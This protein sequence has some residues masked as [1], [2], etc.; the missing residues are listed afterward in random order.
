MF[1]HVKQQAATSTPN[2]HQ[3][4]PVQAVEWA[5]LSRPNQEWLTSRI[6]A[7]KSRTP[8]PGFPYCPAERSAMLELEPGCGVIAILLESPAGG[9]GVHE[10]Q[11]LPPPSVPGTPGRNAGTVAPLRSVTCTRMTSRSLRTVTVTVR[12]GSP[13]ALCR[14][15]LVTSS[16]SRSTAVSPAGC[17]RPSTAAANARATA[18]RS[19][20]PAMVTLS[21]AAALAMTT[22][23]L[24]QPHAVTQ[25]GRPRAHDRQGTPARPT[26]E[27]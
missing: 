21:R 20:R 26:R 3:V 18:T 13:E 23:S 14:T 22:P 19:G 9:Q 25:P 5:E 2:R 4:G 27:D 11:P 7:R 24:P 8:T 1:E 10:V 12:P 16:L 17:C 6:L 15:L